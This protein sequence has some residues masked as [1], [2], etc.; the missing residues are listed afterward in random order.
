[1]AFQRLR[2]EFLAQLLGSR[3]GHE[4][5]GLAL[6]FFLHVGRR[7][8]NFRPRA[9]RTPGTVS[10]RVAVAGAVRGAF[11]RRL[12]LALFSA[13]SLAFGALF[14]ALGALFLSFGSR[15]LKFIID[16]LDQLSGPFS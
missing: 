5:V 11:F 6:D 8:G 12:G 7:I 10:R 9:G 16:G 2:D 3:R 15:R 1:M 14:F 13:L 4:L